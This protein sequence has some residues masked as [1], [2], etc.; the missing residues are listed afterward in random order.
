MNSRSKTTRVCVGKIGVDAGCCWVGDPCYV[1]H[2][3]VPPKDIGRDWDEFCQRVLQHHNPATQ[4]NFDGGH[5]GLGVCVN[6]GGDGQ[7]PV[8]IEVDD[9]G[10]VVSVTV[11]FVCDDDDGEDA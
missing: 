8:F 7:F 10:S 5:A 2:S 9:D 4:F 11:Q 6:T 1:I 3:D